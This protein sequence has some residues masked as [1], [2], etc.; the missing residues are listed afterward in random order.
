LA[1]VEIRSV[2]DLANAEESALNKLP[3]PGIIGMRAKA[4]ALLDARANLAPVSEELAALRQKVEALEKERNE[5][6]EL[7][8]EMAKEADKKR[9]RKPE[10]VA[11]ALG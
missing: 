9:A 1:Q 6:L 10:G 4:K 11:A 8:D 3:I 2:E 5:A 7:A